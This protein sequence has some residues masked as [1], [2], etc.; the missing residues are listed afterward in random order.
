M[1]L[2]IRLPA[3]ARFVSVKYNNNTLSV[4]GCS[5][6]PCPLKDFIATFSRAVPAD[7]VKSCTLVADLQRRS[8]FRI[9]TDSLREAAVLL[10]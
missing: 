4:P 5:A 10:R 2:L 8:L 1:R 6:E 9:I 3:D 7:I